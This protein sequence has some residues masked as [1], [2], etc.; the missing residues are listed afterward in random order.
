VRVN[1]GFVCVDD[2]AGCCCSGVLGEACE[3]EDVAEGDAAAEYRMGYVSSGFGG[4]SE[5]VQSHLSF[6]PEIF[7]SGARGAGERVAGMVEEPAHGHP[8]DVQGLE[9]HH[10]VGVLLQGSGSTPI[11]QS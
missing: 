11:S 6:L 8:A 3:L 9:V 10:S 4:G 7:E 2:V 1:L 5:H